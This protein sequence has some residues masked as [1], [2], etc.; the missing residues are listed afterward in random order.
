[1]IDRKWIDLILVLV[2]V[3]ISFIFS[4]FMPDIVPLSW[5]DCGN[6]VRSGMKEEVVFFIPS[7]II[8][9][10]SIVTMAELNIDISLEKYK[11][12]LR[13]YRSF[14]II[15]LGGIQIYILINIIYKL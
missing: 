6:I 11:K 13:F 7:V 10:Y 12:R 5:N 2:I 15:F 8:F 1:M 4:N 9:I 3:I 14:F